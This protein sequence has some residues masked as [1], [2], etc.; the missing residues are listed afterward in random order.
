MLTKNQKCNISVF[1]MF[2]ASIL[3]FNFAWLIIAEKAD[4]LSCK[5]SLVEII[6][7][8]E[9]KRLDL[10]SELQQNLTLWSESQ[11]DVFAEIRA[12]GDWRP[13]PAS[14]WKEGL[15]TRQTPTPTSTRVHRRPT[16]TQPDQNWTFCNFND[17]QKSA[18]F[19][20]NK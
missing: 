8:P 17:F 15:S 3:I 4:I 12:K 1:L 19:T 16:A 9:K 6:L 7:K 11:V 18:A 10:S 20:S 13:R 5:P 2:A 14:T